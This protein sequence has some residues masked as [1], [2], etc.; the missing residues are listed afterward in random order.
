MDLL[1][2]PMGLRCATTLVQESAIAGFATLQFRLFYIARGA[3]IAGA[4]AQRKLRK[5]TWDK[6]KN[7]LLGRYYRINI[8]HGPDDRLSD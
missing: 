6:S 4:L 7:A 5:P 8:N 3:D 2:G 1:A